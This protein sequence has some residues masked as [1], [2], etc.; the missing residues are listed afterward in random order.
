MSYSEVRCEVG[1]RCVYDKW[2]VF[3]LGVVFV[4][5]SEFECDVVVACT[6][7]RPRFV[8]LEK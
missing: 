2:D 1:G 7:F 3:V 8:F 5:G 4:D 6:G